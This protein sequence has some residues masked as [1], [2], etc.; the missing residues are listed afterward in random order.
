MRR[1]LMGTNFFNR[2]DRDLRFVLFEHLKMADLLKYEAFKDFSLDDF[3]MIIQEAMKVCKEVIG[4][5]NQDGDQEGCTYDK[6]EVKVPKSFHQSL[7][8]NGGK[9]LDF[10]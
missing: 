5:T 2:D 9:Q 3:E 1:H 7:E 8:G 4:P 10:P 6:G